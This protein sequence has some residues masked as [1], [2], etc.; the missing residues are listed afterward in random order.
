MFS[1]GVPSGLAQELAE[2]KR[3]TREYDERSNENPD[4]QPLIWL[5]QA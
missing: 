1:S 5:K 2:N 4:N 3:K